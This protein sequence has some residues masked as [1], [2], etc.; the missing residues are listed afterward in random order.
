[1]DK[2][3]YQRQYYYANKEKRLAYQNDY[4]EKNRESIC[5]YLR[6]HYEDFQREE[7][8]HTRRVAKYKPKAIKKPPMTIEE[9]IKANE[10]K[11]IVQIINE[12]FTLNWS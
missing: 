12:P 3:A 4:R 6:K 7:R 10:T 2:L 5:Q 8:G 1:M 9:H 11:P